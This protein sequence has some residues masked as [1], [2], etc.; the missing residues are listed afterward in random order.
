MKRSLTI[1]QKE[2]LKALLPPVPAAQKHDWLSF[3]GAREIVRK[4]GFKNQKEFSA[5]RR[6]ANIPASPYKIYKHQGW[7][8][9]SDWLGNGRQKHKNL[10][11]HV[12]EA[13]A[14]AE[15]NNGTLP[16]RGWL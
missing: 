14:L 6:P 15:K 1:A 3:E 9:W 13:E 5:W 2:R 16:N 11:E 10:E 7:C 12:F 8:G 4:Q